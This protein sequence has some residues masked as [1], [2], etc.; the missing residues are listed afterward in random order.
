LRDADGVVV[1]GLAVAGSVDATLARAD[2]ALTAVRGVTT[3]LVLALVLV[4]LVALSQV[5]RLLADVRA[6]GSAVVR[7]RGAALP[8]LAGAAA[9]EA[10]GVPVP[11]VAAGGLVAW[12]AFGTVGSP[13]LAPR[14]W[15]AALTSVAGEGVLTANAVARAAAPD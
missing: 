9:V 10:V 15:S 7:A 8:Q 14:A 13:P 6:R 4:A 12:A 11:S 3:A 5:A 1:Q 2:A